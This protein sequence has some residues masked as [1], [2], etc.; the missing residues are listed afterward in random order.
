[1]TVTNI[2]EARGPGRKLTISTGATRTAKKAKQARHSWG[3][4]VEKMRDPVR[5]KEKH[6]EYLKLPKSEQDAIK[7][8]GWFVGGRLRDGVRKKDHLETRDLVTLDIDFADAGWDF[9]LDEAYDDYTFAC[10]T[11]HKHNDDSPR[12]RLVFPLSRSV[13]ADEYPAIARMVASWWDV[14]VFD[15]TTYQASRVMYWPSCSSDGA[16]EFVE[17]NGAFLDPDQVLSS[18]DDWTDVASWP[19]SIRQGRAIE[20]GVEKAADPWAK[21]GSIGDFCRAYP[22]PDA[23]NEFLSDVYVKSENSTE[24][25]FT[26][27]GGSTSNGAIVYNDGRFLF[28]N[29]GTDPA[30][31]RSV[32][33]FDL[34]RL[35]VY[36]HLD[37][38]L[39]DDTPNG[40]RPS[41]EAM[42]G[43]V[44]RDDRVNEARIENLFDDWDA[45]DP[46]D[47]ET[48]EAFSVGGVV[49]FTDEDK[50]EL[51]ALERSKDG[52]VLN[53]ITN[54]ITV[55]K[56]DKRLK[57]AIA[58]N[59]F[60][61]DFVQVRDLPG[62]PLMDSVNG[63]LWQDKQDSFVVA[64]AHKRYGI[65]L[66]KGRLIDAVNNVGLEA[67]FH[68]VR[69]YLKALK[70]D[71]VK[72]LDRL[73]VDHLK[74]DDTAYTRAVTRK[75]F[76]AA[77]ARVYSPGIKFDNLLILEGA[78]GV[79]KSSFLRDMARNWFTDSVG[80]LGKDSVENLKGKWLAEIGELTQ[81]KKA[82]VE[83]IKAFLSRQTDRIR[84]AYARRATDFPRQSVCIGTTNDDEYLKDEEN[85]RFWPVKCHATSF[86]GVM[87]PD[88]IGQVWAEAVV[89]FKAGESLD[90]DDENVRREAR[91][92]QNA[93]QTDRDAVGELAAWLST[94]DGDD[95]DDIDGPERRER[96]SVLEVWKGFFEGRGKPG[97]AERAQIRKLMKLVPGWSDVATPRKVDGVTVRVYTRL[98]DA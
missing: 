5:T 70:W 75:T 65:E 53:H 97:N 31:G 61:Q 92:Q 12:L 66:P 36:G 27:L 3:T 9:D 14:E 63:D 46:A 55:L 90:L 32:N 25:R 82:E 60:A 30:G 41:F 95:F 17:N 89:A 8:V 78:Q 11:T 48:C 67:K 16:F 64:Y 39:D 34:V 77:V 15:D 13:T 98:V 72:R 6:T 80:S 49:E 29:H 23:I 58:W 37:D 40:K 52:D 42:V 68:P 88:E 93:R 94:V 45:D 24:D 38:H 74:A 73:L 84:E 79:G 35:H 50:D 54:A 83:H 22:I 7:D 19:V 87:D 10:Y 44:N 56:Y 86:V 51:K 91:E 71:G 1:M 59:E 96:V 2:E 20:T 33:A 4:L 69:G 62:F 76:T 43:R 26:F 85:R 18:Y 21:P 81:F 57:G 28:S 47:D